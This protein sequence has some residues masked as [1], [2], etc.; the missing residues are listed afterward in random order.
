VDEAVD[1]YKKALEIKPDYS[2][3]CNNLGIVLFQKGQV[4]EAISYYQKALEINPQ[5]VEARG[6][7]AWALATSPQT[8]ILEAV[9]VKLAEQ[10]NQMTGGANPKALRILAAAYAQTGNFSEALKTARLGLQLATNQN[11]SALEKALRKDIG[12]YE[13]GLPCRSG[14]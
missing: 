5:Y 9:A 11:S 2:E 14:N 10:A 3:V 6:N 12:F 13:N 4:E 1:H 8:P 7:L